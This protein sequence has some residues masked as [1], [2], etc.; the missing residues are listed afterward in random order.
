MRRC[1]PLACLLTWTALCGAADKVQPLATLQ[2]KT[3]DESSG[4][5]LG[6]VNPNTFWTHNDSGDGPMLYAFD[7]KGRNRGRLEL[8]GAKARDWE[9]MASYELGK[10]GFLLAADI[11]DNYG[12]W[13]HYTLYITQEPVLGAEA[14]THKRKPDIKVEFVYEDGPHNCESIT[15]DTRAGRILL[16]TKRIDGKPC[17]LYS[18]PLPIRTPDKRQTAKALATLRVPTTTAMDL[19]PDGRRLVVLGYGTKATEWV[20]SLIHI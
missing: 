5:A 1:G 7:R 13:P 10:R 14:R 8:V 18:M 2:D 3:V 4:L 9:D 20:L 11:G 12:M 6:I 16:L 17:K 15:V 19:S